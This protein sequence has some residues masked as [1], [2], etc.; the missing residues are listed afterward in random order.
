MK[1]LCPVHSTGSKPLSNI[2][3]SGSAATGK[4]VVMP[5]TFTSAI[6]C[7]RH[8]GLTLLVFT[9]SG[10]IRI[11]VFLNRNLQQVV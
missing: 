2:R 4:G 7:G 8:I 10:E 3:G 9:V 6:A 5:M 11:C 1:D